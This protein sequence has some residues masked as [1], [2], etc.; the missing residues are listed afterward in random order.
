MYTPSIFISRPP[1]RWLSSNVY[2]ESLALIAEEAKSLRSGQELVD[3][4]NLS[5]IKSTARKKLNVPYLHEMSNDRWIRCNGPSQV[6]YK[7]CSC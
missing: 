4:T 3:P 7:W 5:I 6:N 2:K 1:F